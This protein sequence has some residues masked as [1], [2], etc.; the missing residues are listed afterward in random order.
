MSC[1]GGSFTPDGEADHGKVHHQ[2]LSV[3]RGRRVRM[4]AE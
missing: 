3:P 2:L 4:H 1:G